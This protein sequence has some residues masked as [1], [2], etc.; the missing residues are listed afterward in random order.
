MAVANFS[1]IR[2]ALHTLKRYPFLNFLQEKGVF[3]M[4]DVSG[5][6]TPEIT[7]YFE[8]ETAELDHSLA[9]VG[10]AYKLLSAK[11]PKKAKP[12]S[13]F[14]LGEKEVISD[15]EMSDI[16]NEFDWE[17]VVEKCRD[18]SETIS[19][20]NAEIRSLESEK[21]LLS[22]WTRLNFPLNETKETERAKQ[23]FVSFSDV[24][25]DGFRD[26]MRNIKKAVAKAVG[27]NKGKVSAVVL[28]MKDEEQEV[29][30]LVNKF[31]GEEVALPE[32]DGMASEEIKKIEQNIKE[33]ENKIEKAEKLLKSMHKNIYSLKVVYD[34]FLQKRERQLARR[35]F[36]H[37]EKVAVIQGWVYTEALPMIKNKLEELCEESYVLEK[38]RLT[39]DETPPVILEN[40]GVFGPFEAV[41]GIYGLPKANEPDP[42]PFLSIFFIVFFGLC[43]TDALY[44]FSLS[45]LSFGALYLFKIPKKSRKLFVL[46]GWGGI[47]TM[48]AGVLF[49]G[50]FGMTAE[51]APAFLTT[52]TGEDKQFIF[53]LINPTS[54]NGPLNFLILSFI[55]GIVHVMFGIFVDGYWKIKQGEMTDAILGPFLWLFTIIF[56]ILAAVSGMGLLSL[57]SIPLYIL[58]ASV[59]AL[60]LTQGRDSLVGFA[61]KSVGGKIVAVVAAFFKG[62]LSLYSVVGYFS[63]VLS[64]S[65][66]MALGLGTGIIAYA[67]NI[68]AGIVMGMIPYVGV[69]FAVLILIM[70][71][72]AN[73]GLSALGAFI[74]SGRL[75]YVEFFGKF[76]EGGGRAFKPFHKPSQYT[77]NKEE[78]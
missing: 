68:I 38:I 8:K 73:L 7:S 20:A 22:F 43:L 28:Y 34:Y 67:V 52:G 9:Q 35:K 14:L 29:K 6:F 71:H 48:I 54:G 19:S 64:Y 42:T 3:E 18:A 61:K 49:G 59:A 56:G 75:Q 69:V 45:L 5:N 62:V 66:I 55:I 77:I 32:R 63:D 16:V 21:E 12:L 36:Y 78:F 30:Q 51:Q 1:K 4:E 74:H 25:W 27:N 53:Q 58:L 40:E 41:T 2:I 37:S 26:D 72:L 11:A 13:N 10:F 46:L 17:S 50:Y 39:K 33:D 57:G 31:G 44:G 24:N 15:E 76:L 23:V 65:R 60:V 70:G 47:V